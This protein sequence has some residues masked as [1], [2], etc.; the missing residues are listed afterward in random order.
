MPISSKV[1][2]ERHA[3]ERLVEERLLDFQSLRKE[4][5]F[6]A[7]I[8]L[9]VYAVECLLK[10]HICNTLDLDEMPGTFKSHDLLGLLLHSGLHRRIQAAPD[11]FESLK[12]LD[13]IW[14]PENEERNIR[15]I[16]DPA[17]YTEGL[18]K[19]VHDWMLDPSSGV[20][21]WFRS[22]L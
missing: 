18:A 20:I 6:P 22:R 12:K 11:V 15:Y 14:N 10:V 13:G 2:I 4:K 8:Y 9:G 19:D 17:R 16:D 21:P 5:R 1:T 7:A 3:L